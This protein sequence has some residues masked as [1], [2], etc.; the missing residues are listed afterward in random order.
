MKGSL[1]LKTWLKLDGLALDQ[2]LQA[3]FQIKLH[4]LEEPIYHFLHKSKG[5]SYKQ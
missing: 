1:E 3:N 2:T 4:N 5:N